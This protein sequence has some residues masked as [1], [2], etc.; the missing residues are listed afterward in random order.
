MMNALSV[1]IATVYIEALIHF[2]SYDFTIGHSIKDMP[3]SG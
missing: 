2:Y 1:I 3:V